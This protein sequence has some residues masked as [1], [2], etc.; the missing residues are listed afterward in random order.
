[1][2]QKKYIRNSTAE[3]L[4]FNIEAKEQGVEVIY[5]DET[6]WATQKA[7]ATLFD[8][9]VPAI[10]KHLANIYSEGEL[11]QESTVS[12][13]EIVQTEGNRLLPHV[14]SLNVCRI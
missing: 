3:F 10:S 8:V 2:A 5:H 14:Y 6:I 13:M 11:V 7:I 12:K 1:M 4:I 9:G